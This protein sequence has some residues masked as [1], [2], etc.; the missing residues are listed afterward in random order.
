MAVFHQPLRS[1]NLPG[2]LAIAGGCFEAPTSRREPPLGGRPL[3]DLRTAEDDHRGMDLVGLEGE[4]GLAEFQEHPHAPHFLHREQGRVILSQEI[5]GGV[6]DSF[7]VFGDERHIIT[8][9]GV[10]QALAG[11]GGGT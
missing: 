6:Q 9:D 10:G 11:L 5:A 2:R 4:L 1:L 8:Q 3:D 7:H